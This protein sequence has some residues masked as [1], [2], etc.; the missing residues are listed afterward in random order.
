MIFGWQQTLD[1]ELLVVAAAVLSGCTL[2]LRILV[3]H[4]VCVS[5]DFSGCTRIGRRP[6]PRNKNGGLDM[7]NRAGSCSAFTAALGHFQLKCDADLE[8]L[9]NDEV[10][11]PCGCP[12]EVRT[13]GGLEH[14]V[15]NACGLWYL[16]RVHTHTHFST[17]SSTKLPF[18]HVEVRFLSICAPTPGNPPRLWHKKRLLRALE[19]PLELWSAAL[20]RR[21][22]DDRP[23]PVGQYVGFA[24]NRWL[25]VVFFFFDQGRIL[26]QMLPN[27]NRFCVLSL[28]I[29]KFH[30]AGSVPRHEK[31]QTQEFDNE[32]EQ[33]ANDVVLSRR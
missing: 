10:P 18:S 31:S 16:V 7:H 19:G 26:V 32:F 2:V 8:R 29:G 15:A 27:E 25:S 11:R 6:R 28:S 22:R 1:S 30:A 24:D 12:I 5:D 23:L 21:R 4:G 3:C 17:H 33:T 13:S 9:S 20:W 14:G